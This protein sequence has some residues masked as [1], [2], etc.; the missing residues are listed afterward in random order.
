MSGVPSGRAGR[1]AAASSVAPICPAYERALR[2]C[3]A[4]AHHAQP[5]RDHSVRASRLRSAVAVLLLAL[6]WTGSASAHAYL[7]RSTPATGAAVA[8]APAR[9]LLVF[10]EPVSPAHIDVTSAD[11]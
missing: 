8:S 4:L 11:G 7:V 3:I 5:T 1:H 9:V 2:P 10:D 6:V